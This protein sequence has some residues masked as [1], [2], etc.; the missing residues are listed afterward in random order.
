MPHTI[1]R[2][3]SPTCGLKIIALPPFAMQGDREKFIEAGF[4]DYLAKPTNTCELPG[5][6]QQWL[7]KEGS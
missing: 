1:L 4:D 5:L 6:V 3:D 7:K 2:G